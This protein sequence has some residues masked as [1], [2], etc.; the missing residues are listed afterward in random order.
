MFLPNREP[1]HR[2]A[3]TLI[4]LLIVVGIIAVLMATTLI[5]GVKIVGSGKERVTQ[6]ILQNLDT[7]LN[8]YINSNTKNPPPWVTDPRAGVNPPNANPR[9]VQPVA[10]ARNFVQS[11][12]NTRKIINSGGLALLQ[13]QSS[14]G[15][16]VISQIDAKYV[17]MYRPDYDTG[18]PMRDETD[19]TLQP[20][21]TTVFDGWGNPIRYLHPA[22]KGAINNDT[23]VATLAGPAPQGAAYGITQLRRTST[24]GGANSRTDGPDADGGIPLTNRPYFYSMGVDGKVGYQVTGANPSSYTTQVDWN[25]D[26]LYAGGKNPKYQIE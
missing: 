10:D 14:E 13:L 25:L 8:A 22:F 17:R 23:M 26:N 19:A 21:L 6:G 24:I 16:G 9:I 7:A 2:P 3:F 18:N 5:V 15:A 12:D 20:P 1:H 11:P 4:E